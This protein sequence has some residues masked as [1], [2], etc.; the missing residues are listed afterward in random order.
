MF[1]G[2]QRRR[3][4]GHCVTSVVRQCPLPVVVGASA[5]TAHVTQTAAIK[6]ISR[7]LYVRNVESVLI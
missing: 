5:V 3:W 7:L 4:K 2:Q 1:M 6:F